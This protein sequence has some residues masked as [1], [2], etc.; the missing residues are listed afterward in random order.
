MTDDRPLCILLGGGGHARVLLDA[1]SEE[2]NAL[3]GGILDLERSMWGKK[4]GGVPVLG[5]ETLLAEL[6]ARGFRY[7]AV[8]IGSVRATCRRK[9]LF[10]LGISHKLEPLTVKHPRS[11]CSAKASMGPGTQVFPMAVVNTMARIGPNCIVNSGAIVEHD[12]VLADHVHIA[13]RAVLSGNVCV[14]ANAYIGAGSIILQG[15]KIGE[16]AT[17]GAGAVVTRDVPDRATV[18]GVPAKLHGK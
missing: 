11:A 1:I 13:P 10:D 12:C 6:G 3:S 14:G 17:V 8:G 9:D 18:V 7:F 2:G 16:G 15:L 5:D 4:V